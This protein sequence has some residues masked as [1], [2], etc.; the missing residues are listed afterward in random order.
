MKKPS[1]LPLFTMI[2][3]GSYGRYYRH[4]DGTWVEAYSPYE[5]EV[6]SLEEADREFLTYTIVALPVEESR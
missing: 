5:Q 1:E 3:A 6:L 2:D 4:P